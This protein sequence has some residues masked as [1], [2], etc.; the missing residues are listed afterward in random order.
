M[1]HSIHSWGHSARLK[2]RRLL[3]S[4]GERGTSN[5]RITGMTTRKPKQKPK[6]R[7]RARP[8]AKI[9]VQTAESEA[10]PAALTE[11][12]FRLGEPGERDDVGELLGEAY[13]QSMTSGA[14]AAEEFRDEVLPEETGGPFL[15]T[16]TETGSSD[17]S[18]SPDAERAPLPVA[19]QR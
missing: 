11:Q 9:A 3:P 17:A 16:N 15:E 2:S 19:T 10:T 6:A 5:A 7:K 4:G 1:P 14:Q 13:V 8:M 12:S 18:P